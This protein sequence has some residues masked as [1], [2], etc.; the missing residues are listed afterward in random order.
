MKHVQGT[1]RMPY[2]K[3]KDRCSARVCLV[4]ATTLLVCG[5]SFSAAEAPKASVYTRKWTSAELEETVK[6]SAEWLGCAIG[7]D[8]VAPPPWTPMQVSGQSVRCWGKEFRYENSVFPVSITSLGAEL[9]SGKPA[10]QIK[11]GGQ[12]ITFTDAEVMIERKHDGLVDVRSVSRS[13]D[14]TLEVTVG[15]EF[16]GMGKVTLRLVASD[17]AGAEGVRLDIPLQARRSVL[18]HLTGSRADLKVDGELIRGA[19]YPPMCDS[20]PVP[21]AGRKLDAFREIIWLGDREVGFCWFADSMA[22]WPIRDETDIQVIT[23]E[24]NNG[25]TLQV[26]FA[27]KPFSLAKP[28]EWVFGIQVTPMRPRPADFRTRVGWKSRTNDAPIQQRWNWGDGYY[29]P[30]HDTHP[31]LARAD[32]EAEQAQGKEIMPTSSVEY[33]GMYRFARNTYGPVADPGMIQREVLIWKEEWDQ[34]R[35]LKESPAEALERKNRALTRKANRLPGGNPLEELLARPRHSGP[36]EDW[37][38]VLFKP[39]TYP[40]RFCYNSSFQDYY[41]WK[42]DELVRRTGLSSIYLDQQIYACVNPEHGCGY[43]DYKGEWAGQGNVFAMREMTKRIYM[44]FSRINKRYPEIMWHCS[45]Q[46][47]IPAMSF[48]T[49]Y[50]DGEKYTSPNHTRSIMNHEFYS[51]FLTEE[52]MQVQHMGKPF[53]FVADFLPEINMVAA[54][55]LPIKSPTAATIRDMMGLLMIHDSHLDG[56]GHVYHPALVERIV[57][58]RLAYPLDK[59]KV[60][61]YWEPDSGVA[62]SPRNVKFILHHDSEKA[63][64]ILFNWSDDTILAEAALDYALLGLS[65][66]GTPRVKDVLTGEPVETRGRTVATEMLPRDFRMM[67]VRW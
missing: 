28:H 22:G 47:V 5:N 51:A 64:L 56:M 16:D 7:K 10:V 30:F 38:D 14:Y 24:V 13:G 59:M 39:A 36:G 29:Y 34:M 37:D 57:G 58:A 63:L 54:R 19:A 35:K 6:R 50:F 33:F 18:F 66:A 53:G 25:R 65:A 1:Q 8:E 12:W 43:I 2:R 60:A 31:E 55:G 27:D 46:M 42:L 45:Q 3:R 67:D 26:K 61:Y 52:V 15:Y 49:I 32:V 48:C 9:L 21:A 40:E 23:P 11:S 62:V 4:A 41:V 44:V 17:G 20:G